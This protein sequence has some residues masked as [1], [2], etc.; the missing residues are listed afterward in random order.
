M[1]VHTQVRVRV[2][3]SYTRVSQ[4]MHNL[5]LRMECLLGVQIMHMMYKHTRSCMHT[6]IYKRTHTHTHT[7]TQVSLN[8]KRVTDFESKG[9]ADKA[10]AAKAQVLI[11][12]SVRVCVCVCRAVISSSEGQIDKADAAQAQALLCTGIHACVFACVCCVW[13]R[14]RQIILREEKLRYTYVIACM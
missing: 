5:C 14:G 1:F 10:E 8:I 11:C 4:Y 13:L 2:Y 7:H 3:S 9:Q 12:C 6:N